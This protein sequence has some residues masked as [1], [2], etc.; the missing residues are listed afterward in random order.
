[1]LKI[2]GDTTVLSSNLSMVFVGG[3]DKG[4]FGWGEKVFGYHWITSL[5]WCV[6]D[7]V[8]RSRD[9]DYYQVILGRRDLILGHNC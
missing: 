9:N 1:M 5:R 4:V 3:G 8:K 2:G 6:G 7:K